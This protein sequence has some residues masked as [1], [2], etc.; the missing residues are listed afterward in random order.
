MV[1]EEKREEE[2]RCAVHQPA[3]LTLGWHMFQFLARAQWQKGGDTSCSSSQVQPA[4]LEQVNGMV[5]VS[6]RSVLSRNI[7]YMDCRIRTGALV[8][9]LTCMA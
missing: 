2:Q 8:S 4:D 1:R 6:G 9:A 5:N 3:Q 7:G